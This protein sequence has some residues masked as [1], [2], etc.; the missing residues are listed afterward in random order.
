MVVVARC[1]V[2]HGGGRSTYRGRK[3]KPLGMEKEI[4]KTQMYQQ[5]ATKPR[6]WKT[7][8]KDSQRCGI[9]MKKTIKEKK[10]SLTK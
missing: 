7:I 10:H 9:R 3:G 5:R 2:I 1:E 4:G 6:Y 8:E